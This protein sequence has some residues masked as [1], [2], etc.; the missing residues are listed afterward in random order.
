MQLLARCDG[1]VSLGA[2][3]DPKSV[4][5]SGDGAMLEQV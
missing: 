5:L 3:N 4:T 2:V 1:L